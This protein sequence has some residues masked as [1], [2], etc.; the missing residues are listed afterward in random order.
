MLQ[1]PVERFAKDLA[2]P[3]VDDGEFA[4]LHGEDGI[5]GL[6]ASLICARVRGWCC[7]THHE[8]DGAQSEQRQREGGE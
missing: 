7:C 4:G 2:R 3:H 1:D 8:Q 6:V 5:C